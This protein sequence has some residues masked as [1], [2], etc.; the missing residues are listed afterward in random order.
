MGYTLKGDAT[1]ARC[2]TRGEY[3]DLGVRFE[4]SKGTSGKSDDEPRSG[5]VMQRVSGLEGGVGKWFRFSVRGLAEPNF[6]VENDGLFLRVEYF[7]N[8]G[9]N[10]LDGV[11]QSLWPHIE[12]YRKELAANGK[13]GKNGGAVWKTYLLEFRLPFAEIDT[14]DLI[15]G[16]RN[17]TATAATGTQFYIT[18]FSLVPIPEPENAPKLVMK[19]PG[20]MPDVKSLLHLGGRWYY[21]PERVLSC[22]K[23]RSLSP[24][25]TPTNSTISIAGSRIRLPRT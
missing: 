16:F 17:A 8:H 7:G 1:W 20:A 6:Q 12:Q 11:T 19:K 14:L 21:R 13:Y 18:D 3:N 25:R 5:S 9:A 4:S 10:A 15:A 24:R 22:G 23:T 2:G